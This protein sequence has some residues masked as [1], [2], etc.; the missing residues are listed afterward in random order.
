MKK[1]KDL[2]KTPV[3]EDIVVIASIFTLWP[4]VLRRENFY[5]RVVMVIALLILLFIV[6]RRIKRFNK[7]R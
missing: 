6:V 5:S 4:A 7:S 3:W 1:N 2:E